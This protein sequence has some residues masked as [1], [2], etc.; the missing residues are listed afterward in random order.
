MNGFEKDQYNIAIS[1]CRDSWNPVNGFEK[2]QYVQCLPLEPD[3]QTS[4]HHRGVPGRCG[5][6]QTTA[7]H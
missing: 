1:V 3:G 2:D 6:M 5:Q 7:S 4:Q